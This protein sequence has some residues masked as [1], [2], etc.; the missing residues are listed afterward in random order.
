METLDEELRRYLPTIET[1]RASA[2][3]LPPGE[4]SETER[5][6]LLIVQAL[7]IRRTSFTEIAPKMPLNM[8]RGEP[9][10][11]VDFDMHHHVRIDSDAGGGPCPACTERP[12][13]RRCRVCGGAGRLFSGTQPCSC[14]GG[15][16]TCANCDG[17][18]T[19]ARTLLRYYTD[20]PATLNE[21]YMPTHVGHVPSLFS[22]ESTMEEDI[23][24]RAPPPEVM[25]CHDLTGR[26]SGSAYRGGGRLVRP[27]FHGFDFGDT[28]DKS[29]AGLAAMGAGASV[30]R[31]DIRAYAWPFLRMKWRGH[32]DHAVYVDRDGMPKVFCGGVI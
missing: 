15:F 31:Y 1:A 2:V 32:P 19:D 4:P 11:P 23:A 8:E 26:V 12:G 7:F 30:V 29:L 9:P 24:F 13:F 20:T 27:D 22:L 18:G 10:T 16:V 17:S 5:L 14:N 21:A 25:R 6:V 28:I 3:E